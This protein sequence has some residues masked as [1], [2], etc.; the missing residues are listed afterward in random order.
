MDIKVLRTSEYA[1]AS[2][3]AER[4][5]NVLDAA[6][7]SD[8][9]RR[10]FLSYASLVCF[11]FRQLGNHLSFGAHE[12]GELIGIVEVRDAR[13]ISMLFVEPGKTRH[14]VATALFREALR[15]IRISNRDIEEITVNSSPYARPF[16]EKMGFR[17]SAP[18]VDEGGFVY[19][20][21][22][23]RL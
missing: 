15:Y 11:T 13:H 4:S 21:M 14:G 22:S 18:F 17:Q 8:Y 16:Y 6:D 7:Y 2:R 19:T 3:L 12:N 1:A 5:F 10:S 23:L 20:P 9:G